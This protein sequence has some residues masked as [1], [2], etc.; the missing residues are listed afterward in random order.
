MD[1]TEGSPD[2]LLL[3]GY[4]LSETGLGQGARN[5]AHALEAGRI[6][7][8]Y[9]AAKIKDRSNDKEFLGKIATHIE[10]NNTFSVCGLPDAQK[11][12]STIQALGLN[13][14]NYLYPSWELDR[15]P[16]SMHSALT[17]YDD[18]FVPSQFIADSLG[19]FLGRA[20]QVIPQPV[21]IPAV[22]AATQ[23]SGDTLK[24]YSYLDFDSWV[25]RK[26]PEGVLKAF[27]L[28]FPSK[29]DDVEL[30]LKVKGYK[31]RGGRE[32]LQKCSHL[33][34][35]IKLIDATL[36][37]TAVDKLMADCHVFLSMHRSE[38]FGFGPAEALA[39]GKIVVATDYSGTR[40]FVNKTTGYPVDYKLIPVKPDEYPYAE[41]QLWADPMIDAAAHALQAIYSHP[42]AALERAINGREWM[43]RH[44]SFAATGQ[45]LKSLFATQ[46]TD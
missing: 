15:V 3:F 24:I 14:K 46:S 6:P 13:K 45:L 32:I 19:Q 11:F 23:I 16:Y 38:G 40:D 22:T 30:T 10:N 27:Q 4:L 44:H 43:I 12:H 8:T 29:V 39:A 7:A 25:A 34:P 26:N 31:D 20:I 42:H 21:A 9:V 1:H 18:I 33:D 5:I 2:R 37:R 17:A 35:R 36:D 41:N 28:A